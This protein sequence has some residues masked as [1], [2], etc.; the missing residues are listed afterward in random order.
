MM[1]KVYLAGSLRTNWQDEVRRAL[2]DYGA[3]Q[4]SNF[5]FLDPSYHSEMK[6]PDQYWPWDMHMIRQ[7]DIVFVYA[8][9]TNPGLGYVIE[10][11]YAHGLG[12]TVVL[13]MPPGHATI[14][15]RYRHSLVYFADAKFSSL[16]QGIEFLKALRV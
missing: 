15:D 1:Q 11:G 8:D 16:E 5:T 3:S 10:A 2:N 4:S 9:A 14:P 7:A 13:V 6:D 12:K